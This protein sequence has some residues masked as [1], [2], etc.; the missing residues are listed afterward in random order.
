[1]TK[2]DVFSRN[3]YRVRP[4]IIGRAYAFQNKN[5]VFTNVDWEKTAPCLTWL[6]Q[7][8]NDIL[9]RCAIAARQRCKCGYC[10]STLTL[11][12]RAKSTVTTAVI[13]TILNRS[14]AI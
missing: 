1:M 7:C 5:A 14:V 12:T 9:T 11:T 8:Y 10:S 6:S 3:A 13:S 4:A 2:C